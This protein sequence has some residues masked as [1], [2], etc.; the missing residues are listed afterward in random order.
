MIA[1]S[2]SGCRKVSR[3]RLCV[4]WRGVGRS[5]D[6]GVCVGFRAFARSSRKVVLGSGSGGVFCD[7]R[8]FWRMVLRAAALVAQWWLG[9][10]RGCGAGV[11]ALGARALRE[12]QAGGEQAGSGLG[13]GGT[14]LLSP[15][16]G[17]GL[18]VEVDHRAHPRRGAGHPAHNAQVILGGFISEQTWVLSTPC[19]QPT[20][21]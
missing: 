4:P 2:P 11:R 14:V 12:S 16:G 5:D 7:F 9:W 15:V 19:V 20:R 13:V 21:M 18:G 6:G 3:S 1:L 10:T 17:M 8:R